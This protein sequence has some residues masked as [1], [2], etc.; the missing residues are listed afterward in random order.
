MDINH[1][2][3]YRCGMGQELV[4]TNV[5]DVKK[6]GELVDTSRDNPI[7]NV[8][9]KMKDALLLYE[10]NGFDLDKALTDGGYS[11]KNLRMARK[12][13][14]EHPFVKRH[15]SV[16]MENDKKFARSK[17]VTLLS[18]TM[19]AHAQ[20]AQTDVYHAGV[21]IKLT[22]RLER[23]LGLTDEAQV[24]PVTLDGLITAHKAKQT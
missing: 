9:Q 24:K 2:I 22:E 15:I 21:L 16:L 5:V 6:N 3:W 20:K 18:D 13:F 8:Q 14:L 17:I 19:D 11:T 1:Y 4:T 10:T 12:R 7:T 23:L